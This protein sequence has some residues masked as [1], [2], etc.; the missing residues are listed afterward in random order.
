MWGKVTVDETDR[1]NVALIAVKETTNDFEIV[2]TNEKVVSVDKSNLSAIFH[3][4]AAKETTDDSVI[5]Q[6][7]PCTSR[8]YKF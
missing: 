6:I 7:I 2:S 5:N 1:E 8:L 4:N 3:P